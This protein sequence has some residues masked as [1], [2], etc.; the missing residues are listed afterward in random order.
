MVEMEAGQE[1]GSVEDK[2]VEQ[3]EGMAKEEMGMV[4]GTVE[5]EKAEEKEV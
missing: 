5:M 4:E 3:E 1:E 2:A